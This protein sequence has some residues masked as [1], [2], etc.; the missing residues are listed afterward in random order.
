MRPGTVFA[1]AGV[2]LAGVAVLFAFDGLRAANGAIGLLAFGAALLGG[3]AVAL[4]ISTLLQRH[5]PLPGRVPLLL[6]VTAPLWGK[7]PATGRA[8]VAG[9]FAGYFGGLVLLVV[10]RAR[11]RRV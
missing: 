2:L 10:R 9:A 1:I 4:W 11:R 5:G 7:L 8:A 3:V 6:L